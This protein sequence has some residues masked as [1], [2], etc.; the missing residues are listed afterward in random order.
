MNKILLIRFS[1]IGDIVLTTPVIRA[2]K[3][4]TDYELHVLTKKQYEGLYV[5]NPYVDKVHSFIKYI[6]ECLI[7]LKNEKFD[8]IV[9]L[10]KNLRSHKLKRELKVKNYSFPKLNIEKWILVNFKINKLP[11]IHIVDRY[12][13][14][15]ES[16]GIVNDNMGL[17]YYIPAVD[18]VAPEKIDSRLKN[19]YI[20]FVIGGQHTTKILPPEKAALILAKIEMPIVL[21]GGA[22]DKKRGEEISSLTSKADIINTCGELNINQS[23]SIVKSSKAVLT[24]DTGLMHIAAAFNKPIISIWGNTIPEF[25]MYPYMPKNKNRYFI[26]EVEG[27]RCRP[28][29]KLGFNKCPKRHFRCMEDQDVNRIVD[30][31]KK[32]LRQEIIT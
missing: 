18:E 23:A 31:V 19:E 3:Q 20:A 14:A 32:F 10:Q 22:E 15:V 2:I 9:D 25:G 5:A 6:S 24:N 21:L 13:K 28:C 16:L 4:Q 11:N 26:S 30:K 1:S 8:I 17:E 7:D 27:L 29:S 12:F